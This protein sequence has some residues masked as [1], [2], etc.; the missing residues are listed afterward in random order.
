[1]NYGSL[2]NILSEMGLVLDYL[3]Q[4]SEEKC[5]ALVSGDTGRLS[6]IVLSETQLI[7]QLAYLEKQYGQISPESLS[8]EVVQGLREKAT[9]LKRSNEVNQTLIEQGLRIVEHEMRFF[10]SLQPGY[11]SSPS[12]PLVFDKRA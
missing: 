7:E 2:S 5:Q 3:I 9:T 12:R 4:Y 6:D 10:A 11:N 1:M 8:P